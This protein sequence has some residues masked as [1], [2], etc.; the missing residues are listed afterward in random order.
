M[1]LY[2]LYHNNRLLHSCKITN[3]TS[4]F[5]Y[6]SKRK[7]KLKMLSLIL[8][9]EIEQIILFMISIGCRDIKI[10]IFNSVEIMNEFSDIYIFFSWKCVLLGIYYVFFRSII[11]PSWDRSVRARDPSKR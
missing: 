1:S 7:K 5:S 4:I 3:D 10:Q 6:T 11:R 9:Q 8:T 2:A